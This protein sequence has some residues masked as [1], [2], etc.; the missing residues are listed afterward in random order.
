MATNLILLALLAT[1][2]VAFV[3]FG[4]TLLWALA[5]RQR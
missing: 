1:I 3:G 4:I 2:T 5:V